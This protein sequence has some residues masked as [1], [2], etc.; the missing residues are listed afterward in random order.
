MLRDLP[1]ASG[2]PTAIG[3]FRRFYVLCILCILSF[4]S[5]SQ[6]RNDKTFFTLSTDSILSSNGEMASFTVELKNPT[7]AIF[8]GTLLISPEKGTELISKNKTPLQLQPG[9]SYFVAIKFLM[10]KRMAAGQTST[11][12]VALLN[13]DNQPEQENSCALAV[14]ASKSVSL[15]VEATELLLKKT[16]DSL[17][18]PVRLSNTGN[19][20]QKI[21]VVASLPGIVKKGSHLQ[22]LFVLPAFHDTLIYFR[23]RISSEMFKTDG[24]YIT[25]TGLYYGGDAFGSQS[26]NAQPAR[27]S[28]VFSDAGNGISDY[29]RNSLTLAGQGLGT[30]NEWYQLLSSGVVDMR[31]QH[32]YYNLDASIYKHGNGQGL[33]LLNTFLTYRKENW[34]VTAGNIGRSYDLNISGRGVVAYADDSSHTNSAEAGYVDKTQN[35]L[36][37]TASA[38]KFAIKPGKSAWAAYTHTT[39]NIRWQTAAVYDIN[40]Y[41]STKTFLLTNEL[42]WMTK[43]RYMIKAVLNGGKENSLLVKDS[44]HAGFSAGIGFDGTLGKFYI[45]SSNTLSSRY[46]PGMTKGSFNINERIGWTRRSFGTW[47]AMSYFSMSPAPFSIAGTTYTINSKRLRG[48]AGVSFS[49]GSTS[50]SVSPS[51]GMEKSNDYFSAGSMQSYHVSLTVNYIRPVHFQ[52]IYLSYEGGMYTSSVFSGSRFHQKTIFNLRYKFISLNATYQLGNFYLSEVVNWKGKENKTL[53]ISP[54]FQKEILSR[55]ARIQYSPSYTNSAA[56]GTMIQQTARIEYDY[57][58]KTRFFA[59]ADYNYYGNTGYKYLSV[60]AGVTLR[61]PEAK[62]GNK[63]GHALEVFLYKDMNENG[64][65]DKEDSVATNAYVTINNMIFITGIDGTVKYR[66]LP[67]GYY[68]IN[69]SPLK[70]WFGQEKLVSSLPKD[71]RVE[72]PMQKTGI[73]KGNISYIFSQFSYETSANKE[74]VFISAVNNQGVRFTAMTNGDGQFIFYLPSGEYDIDLKKE[75]MPDE[76]ECINNYKRVAISPQETFQADFVLKVKERKTDTKK[77]TSRSVASAGKP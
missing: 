24:F 14:V 69:V 46:Y 23:K 5:F 12:K 19:T 36:G 4:Q 22:E 6:N 53:T 15:F 60:K 74:G 65:F 68:R 49:A 58:L 42:R 30:E 25:V 33:Q 7:T 64:V 26:V 73:V 41:T 52:S 17:E 54:Q 2:I 76:I 70:G 47:A 29:S 44:S 1:H 20:D 77:F 72:I 57:S 55:R 75:N 35:L 21:L 34:G 50:F 9:E 48:E 32:I 31:Q 59:G 27:S 13:S 37:A 71:T 11:I 3:T 8:S 18:I 62:I 61:L 63:N 45:S 39:Q 51:Y 10:P 43:K 28:R 56:G 16:L 40:G 67:E 66:N 38:S